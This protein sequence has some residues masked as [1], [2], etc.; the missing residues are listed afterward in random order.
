[1]FLQPHARIPFD[2]G[3]HSDASIRC[4][5]YSLRILHV[6]SGLYLITHQSSI[7]ESLH[8]RA[9]CPQSHHAQISLKLL[10]HRWCLVGGLIL[11]INKFQGT[12]SLSR[13]VCST[14]TFVFL[15]ISSGMSYWKVIYVILV[16]KE[17]CSEGGMVPTFPPPSLALMI[18]AKF[19]MQWFQPFSAEF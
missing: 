9:R 8:V 11:L 13:W 10:V 16:H 7:C 17:T 4:I 15:G 2:S 3:V 5:I 6:R 19:Q 14:Y 12:W 1:M 18:S